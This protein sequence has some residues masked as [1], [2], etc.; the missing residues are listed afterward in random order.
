MSSIAA[1]YNLRFAEAETR[2]NEV[3]ALAPYD[4]RG[5]FF[6]AIAHYYRLL[7]SRVSR[8]TQAEQEA[9]LRAFLHAAQHT[10]EVCENLL[11]RNPKDGKALFYIGGIYGYRGIA[12]GLNATSTTEYLSAARDAYKGVEYLK[13]SLA[14]DPQNADI[15]M[16]LGL[17]NYVIS[18]TPSFAQSIIKLAGLTGNRAEGLRQLEYAAAHGT[19][20]RAEAQSWL[21]QI[22][23][24][25]IFFTASEGYYD[26]AE[27]HYTS[28]LVAYPDN[29]LLRFFYGTFLYEDMRRPLDALAQYSAASDEKGRAIHYLAAICAYRSGIILQALGRYNE[30]IAAFQRSL[31]QHTDLIQSAYYQ[32]GLCHDMQ[33][34]RTLALQ[35]YAQAKDILA[36]RQRMQGPLSN[37]DQLLLKTTWAFDCGNDAQTITLAKE[38]LQRSDLTI[39]ERARVQY[40]CGRAYAAQGDV[41]SAE[42]C[43]TQALALVHDT[44]AL[45]A[46]LHYHLAFVYTKNG[47]KSDAI[48]HLEQALSFK[49]Y[50]GERRLRR[51]IEREL[52]R[53]KAHN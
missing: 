2:A 49:E 36:A 6:R 16:G 37:K 8:L 4:P 45:Q 18:Q 13:Q 29:T 17:F 27:Q 5:Y 19:Y 31:T 15:S 42:L 28:F 26:K 3:I 7:Y 25:G 10:I 52:Y 34:H 1:L 11:H 41:S 46:P 32:I 21:A 24:R 35:A 40:Y 43:Y 48:Y 20:A 38:C 47:K 14:L 39:T 23:S 30:A 9:N 22:Y 12:V 51:I 33:G 44:P 50:T 53:L